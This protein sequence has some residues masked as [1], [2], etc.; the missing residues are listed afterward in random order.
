[1]RP[2][3]G[4]GV[5]YQHNGPQ[6]LQ[7][8]QQ[9]FGDRLS[10]VSVVALIDTAQAADFREIFSG[11]PVIHHLSGVAPADTYGPSLDVLRRQDEISRELDAAWCGEDI[12]AWSLGPYAIPYFAPPLFEASVADLVADRIR[13]VMDRS[14]VA[15]LAEIPSCSFVVGRLTL[16]EFFHRLVDRSGC[17]VVLDISH[18]FSYA[19]YRGLDPL[20]VLESLPL[21]AVWQIHIAGGRISDEQSYYYIDS[22]DDLIL[23]E[24]E[25]LLEAALSRCHELRAITYEIGTKLSDDVLDQEMTR[26]ETL[27]RARSYQSR[28]VGEGVE[29][30]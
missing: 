14:S 20:E 17:G 25:A 15:F 4:L 22:H 27:L 30:D 26:V 2:V 9:R 6:M 19:L 5:D 23:P 29:H 3:L 16:G 8:L 21:D 7:R 13:A 1:M 11:L 24:V 18:V 28:L 12:G 10:H